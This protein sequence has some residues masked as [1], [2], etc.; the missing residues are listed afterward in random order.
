MH[1]WSASSIRAD[2]SIVCR[3]LVEKSAKGEEF[4]DYSIHATTS[5]TFK[6]NINRDIGICAGSICGS[7]F[8]QLR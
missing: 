6:R 2:S 5:P 7:S 4:C 8:Q 1:A 3:R